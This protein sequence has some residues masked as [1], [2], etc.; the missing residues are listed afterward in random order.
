MVDG[1]ID[2]LPGAEHRPSRGQRT[3][4]WP[5][6]VRIYE[7]RLW[8]RNPIV[9]R[10]M[11]ISF[12]DEYASI[13]KVGGF[14][15]AERVLDL[16]CGPGIYAR[17]FAR[18]APQGVV[19]GLD[20]SPPMLAYAARQREKEG[21]GNLV[22]VHGSAEELPFA[23]E[24]FD[25]ANCCGA[26]H[27]FPDLPRALAEVT[28]V[29]R[30]GSR[31]TAAVFRHQETGLR[32]RASEVL[33]RFLGLQPFTPRSLEEFFARAGL[34]DFEVLHPGA[35]WLVASARKPG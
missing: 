4:E 5:P 11:G 19:V 23:A 8:R 1:V 31:F 3:M 7:S 35:I 32:A 27:L 24:Y 14:T 33:N 28:R 9:E 21:I 10:R 15:D 12:E 13:A 16:A 26:L 20:L 2:M 17:R 6:L 22:L 30:P 34:S 29:L 25:A 18:A